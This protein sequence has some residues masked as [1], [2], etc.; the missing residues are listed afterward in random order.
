MFKTVLVTRTEATPENKCFSALL[1]LAFVSF[2]KRI[3]SFACSYASGETPWTLHLSMFGLDQAICV[4]YNHSS[5]QDGTTANK[6]KGR[7]LNKHTHTHSFR[8][9]RST[10]SWHC[11]VGLCTQHL[12]DGFPCSFPQTAVVPCGQILL[13]LVSPRLSQAAIVIW[14]RL[15]EVLIVYYQRK[16]IQY[17]SEV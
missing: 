4:Y 3:Y 12:S 8:Q 7:S 5:A 14:V 16:Y 11:I 6:R 1:F 9:H 13:I 2:P 10:A 15:S 17:Q